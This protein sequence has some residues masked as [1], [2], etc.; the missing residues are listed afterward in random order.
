MTVLAEKI[1]RTLRRR[2]LTLKNPQLSYG[3]LCYLLAQR[4]IGIHHRDRRLSAALGEVVRFCH[5][6][7]LPALSALV[8]R[9]DDRQMPGKSYYPIA[10][11]QHRKNSANLAIAWGNEVASVVKSRRSYPVKV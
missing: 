8:G 7:R 11:P 2:A 10:H 5:S 3:Y 6:L 9:G 1:Y 4:G